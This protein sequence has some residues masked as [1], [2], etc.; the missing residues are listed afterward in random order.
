VREE[1]EAFAVAATALEGKDVRIVGWSDAAAAL[2]LIE[3]GASSL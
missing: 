3:S 1:L 2:K